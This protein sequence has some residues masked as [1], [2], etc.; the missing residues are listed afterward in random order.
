[1]Y[2][3]GFCKSVTPTVMTTGVLLYLIRMR[4]SQY[5]LLSDM[6]ELKKRSEAVSVN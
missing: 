4:K 2:V 5:L 3:I 1:M 6:L